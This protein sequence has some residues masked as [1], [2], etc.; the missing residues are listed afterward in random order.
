MVELNTSGPRLFFPRKILITSCISLDVFQSSLL[1]C[2]CLLIEGF[3]I[4]N[5]KSYYWTTCIHSCCSV[6]FMVSY[7][8]FFDYMHWSWLLPLLSW[9]CLKFSS[10]LSVLSSGWYSQQLV[11]SRKCWV[12]WE[13]LKSKLKGKES[14][15]QTQRVTTAIADLHSHFGGVYN[16]HGSTALRVSIRK[17][18]KG[19]KRHPDCEWLHPMG[20]CSGGN[21]KE[22]VVTTSD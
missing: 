15:H 14:K 6:A 11:P 13:S 7:Y 21:E 22:K 1:V 4:I 17:L 8:T 5:N 20:W 12:L 2:V 18:N 16:H 3:E 19:G 10:E 9:V